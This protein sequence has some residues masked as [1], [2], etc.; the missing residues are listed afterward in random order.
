M[1]NDLGMKSKILQ[2]LIKEIMLMP[3][4]E[5]Q[6]QE[7]GEGAGLEGLEDALGGDE[8]G[9]PGLEG[10]EDDPEMMALES[11]PKMKGF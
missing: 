2:Q 6:G 11:K 8:S 9:K 10:D 1:L 4:G 5:A 3:D 7:M